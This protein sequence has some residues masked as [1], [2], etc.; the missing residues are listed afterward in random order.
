MIWLNKCSR[1]ESGG[2]CLQNCCQSDLPKIC[3]GLLFAHRMEPRIVSGHP[4]LCPIVFLPVPQNWSYLALLPLFMLL[5][6]WGM[7]YLDLALLTNSS[8]PVRAQLK[9]PLRAQ[10]KY[11]FLFIPPH[12]RTLPQGGASAFPF[13]F[14]KPSCLL[15]YAILNH[16]AV[17]L[18]V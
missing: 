15:S 9:Y 5:W 3:R 7:P 1:V 2:S 10:L 13:A 12:P 14:P 4:G 11:A 17:Y 6:L 18:S 16:V 8:S